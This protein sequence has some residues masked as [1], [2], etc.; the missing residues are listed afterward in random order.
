MPTVRQRIEK[1]AE[2]ARR[3][4]QEQQISAAGPGRIL[5]DVQML[6]DV[7]GPAG[8]PTKS[9]QGLLPAAALRALNV[10]LSAPIELYLDRALQ[11]DY[12]NIAG[13]YV[14]LRVIGI[15]CPEP[16][17]LVLEPEAL[18]LW[19]GLNPTEKDFALAG[20]LVMFGFLKPAFAAFFPEGKRG[21]P[22]EIFV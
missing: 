10:Q 1:P 17:R 19:N 20:S 12:P 15:A 9:T 2:P 5:A 16:G 14:L 13:L 7:I 18:S 11:R 22:P 8:I 3:L 6:L 21:F 4:L